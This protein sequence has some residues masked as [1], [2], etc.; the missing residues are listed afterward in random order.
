MGAATARRPAGTGSTVSFEFQLQPMTREPIPKILP[1]RPRRLFVS[2]IG[3]IILLAIAGAASIP[4]YF[5]SSSILYKFGPDRHFLRSGQVAGIVAGFLLMLQIIL[6]M[7]LK[8]LDRVFG[9]NSLFKFHRTTAIIIACLTLIH[10]GL[11]FIPEDRITIPLQWRYWPEFVG[12]FL[13]LLIIATVISGHWRARLKLPFHRWWPI[14]Q[15][16]AILIIAAFWLHV[17]AVSDTFEQ[18]LP[19]LLAFCAIGLCGLMFF[20]LRTRSLRNRRRIFI[21]S[22]V[23]PAGED[24]VRLQIT[25][26]AQNMLAHAP[27]QFCFI[28]FLS[29]RISKEEHPFTIASSPARLGFLEFI[30]RTRGDWTGKLNNLRPGDRAVIHGPFGLFSHLRFSSKKEIIMI[31]GGIGIT[32]MLSMLRYMAGCNDQRKITLIWSNQTQKHIILPDEFQNLEAQLDGLRIF[33][34]LTRAPE[35]A[36]E[37]RRLDRL[38]LKS[39]LSGC[40]NSSAIFVCGPHQMMKDVFTSLVSLGFEKR[41]IFTERFSL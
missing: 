19:K 16:A 39:L 31:A 1:D 23:D 15:G 5:E 20:W 25:S 41:M 37:K 36:G 24:S 32:P 29:P 27:G 14:H 26:K 6:S 28:T 38:K 17:L 34:V 7:R 35:F 33:H 12:L 40:S 30:V 2:L 21:V 11:I 13:L 3:F 8:C 18:K 22:A 9:L 10:P 4:F